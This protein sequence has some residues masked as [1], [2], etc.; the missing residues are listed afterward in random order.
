MIDWRMLN[1]TWESNGGFGI[2][3]SCWLWHVE[4]NCLF[5]F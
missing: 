2:V 1:V 4:E 5:D 3:L